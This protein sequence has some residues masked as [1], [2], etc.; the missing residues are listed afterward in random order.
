MSARAIGCRGRFAAFREGECE[1]AL[2][3]HDPLLILCSRFG[4]ELPWSAASFHWQLLPRPARALPPTPG[5]SEPDPGAPMVAILVEAEDRRLVA[6]RNL[7]LTPA[8][9]RVLHETILEQ[10]RYSYDPICARRA[11]E[12]LQRRYPGM[13]VLVAYSSVRMKTQRVGP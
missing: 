11:I 6:Q 3:I 10:A 8:F 5:A 2:V 4:D 9:T 13:G 12:G 1:L 7:L